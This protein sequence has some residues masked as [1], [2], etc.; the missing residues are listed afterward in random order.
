M[1]MVMISYNSA[2][3]SEVMEVL[4][5]SGIE[6]FTKWT[7]VQGKGKLSGPHFGDEIWPGENSVVFVAVGNE[8]AAALLE[9]VK[10]LRT[11]LGQEGIKAFAWSLEEVT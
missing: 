6:S 2:I 5:K 11:K 4:E 7:P 9:C 8:D 3:N 10:G 1:R